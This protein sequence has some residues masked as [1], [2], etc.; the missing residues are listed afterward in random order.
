MRSD[1]LDTQEALD[2]CEQLL[3]MGSK[4]VILSGGETFLRQD[5]PQLARCLLQGGARV[6]I[7]S[8]GLTIEQDPTIIPTLNDIRRKYGSITIG[9]S[10]DGG[11]DAHELI[12]GITGCYEMVLGCIDKLQ[13]EGFAVI[14][15]TTVNKI[16]LADIRALRDEI[17]FPKQIY[18]WQVQTCNN[19]GRMKGHQNWLLSKEEYIE[20]V[21]ILA[22]SRRMR[23]ENP[24]TDPADC[25]GYFTDIERDLRPSPWPGCQAGLRTIGIQS[26]GNIKGCLSLLDDIFIEGNIRDQSLSEIWDRPGAFAYNREFTAD[27]L[28]GMCAGCEHGE[29]C[30]AGC[31]GVS[32]SISGSFYNAPYCIYGF[33]K[34]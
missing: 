15:L 18:A 13:A 1:E 21:E 20:L 8:N 25:I 28:E 31:T 12:R 6:G 17:I 29:R 27:M 23:S 4:L 7:I 33:T 19:Y 2:L 22:E 11:K 30:A 24:R 10:L 32:H 26:N 5:W 34:L 16:N 14:V 3:D 9:L